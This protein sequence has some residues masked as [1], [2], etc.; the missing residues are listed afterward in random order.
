MHEVIHA[1]EKKKKTW[2][3]VSEGMGSDQVA[4][5]SVVVRGDLNESEM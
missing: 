4:V 1:K 3:S 2:S 5:F